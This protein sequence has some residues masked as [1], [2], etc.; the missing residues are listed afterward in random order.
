MLEKR[1]Q[2]KNLFNVKEWIDSILGIGK[3]FIGTLAVTDIDNNPYSAL[4]QFLRTVDDNIYF[5]ADSISLHG[6]SAERGGACSI[7]I[8]DT[9]TEKASELTGGS[10]T[11][12][13]TPKCLG[14]V[15]WDSNK[16]LAEIFQNI[17]PQSWEMYGSFPHQA[18]FEC[19]PYTAEFFRYI[20]GNP[21]LGKY[22]YHP[23]GGEGLQHIED[24][25]EQ[26]QVFDGN[27]KWDKEDFKEIEENYAQLMNKF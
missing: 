10:L 15:G 18:F 12:F 16:P 13:C 5:I 4:V 17:Y 21:Y 24:Y 2:I 26:L 7:T 9:E 11:L 25:L 3:P 23:N 22:H 14:S 6:R 19:I 27:R 20:N 1:K 8:F